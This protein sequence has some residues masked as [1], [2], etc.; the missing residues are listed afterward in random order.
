MVAT[1]PGNPKQTHQIAAVLA[2]AERRSP[3]QL[4]DPQR[5]GYPLAYHAEYGYVVELLSFDHLIFRSEL[6]EGVLACVSSKGTVRCD[7]R[8]HDRVS[9]LA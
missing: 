4:A 8:A 9:C 1:N 5:L 3:L 7:P 6:D 2:I